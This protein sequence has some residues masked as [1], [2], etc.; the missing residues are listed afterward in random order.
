[1]T[2]AACKTGYAN[3]PNLRLS[4][5]SSSARVVSCLFGLAIESLDCRSRV[6]ARYGA[7]KDVNRGVQTIV[8]QAGRTF[9]VVIRCSR[10]TPTRVLRYQASSACSGTCSVSPWITLA[11]VLY[12]WPD[13]RNPTHILLKEQDW[14]F[15]TTRT[16]TR[17][18]TRPSRTTP[19]SQ[20]ASQQ[21]SQSVLPFFPQLFW[22]LR[23]GDCVQ[24]DDRVEDTRWVRGSV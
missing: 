20:S 12:R 18:R 16:R 13:R 10:P 7:T 19:R 4:S 17:T 22:I 11:Y 2:S 14:L 1:M 8:D 3:N 5:A 6:C 9:Q 21:T 23:E 24:P 15:S